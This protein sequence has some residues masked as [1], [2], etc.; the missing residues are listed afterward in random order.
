[1][2]SP[3]NDLLQLHV[4]AQVVLFGVFPA[5]IIALAV[6]YGLHQWRAARR[7]RRRADEDEP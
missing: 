6:A 2:G 4:G 3:G 1:V 5:I 7:E